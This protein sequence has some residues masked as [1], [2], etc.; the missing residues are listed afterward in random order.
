[1]ICVERA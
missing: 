1:M